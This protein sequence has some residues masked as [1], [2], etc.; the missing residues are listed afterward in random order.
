VPALHAPEHVE[1]PVVA[2]NF[3]AGQSKQ[4]AVKKEVAPNVVE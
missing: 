2:E 4:A 1:A 3:P